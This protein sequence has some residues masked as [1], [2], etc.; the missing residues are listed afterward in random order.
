[1]QKLH[2]P[3][4]PNPRSKLY[5]N[6][7]LSPSSPTAASFTTP[8][9][10]PKDSLISFPHASILL[11]TL[12]RPKDLNCINSIGHADLDAL[13]TWYDAEPT[14]LCAL[15]TGGT[16][17]AFCAG[18]DLKEWNT[19]TNTSKSPSQSKSPSIPTLPSMP[20]P[21]PAA[22]PAAAAKNQ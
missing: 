16:S 8:P 14:L 22:S 2:P 1:I 15:L 13:F 18:A 7:P 10:I 5:E 17:R 20:P 11:I 6:V 9:P 12:N 4:H 21:A 19:T 3:P